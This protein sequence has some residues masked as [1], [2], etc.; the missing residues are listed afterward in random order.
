MRLF[1]IFSGGTRHWPRGVI[2]CIPKSKEVGHSLQSRSSQRGEYRSG[3]E[4]S[5]K[6][7]RLKPFKLARAFELPPC[8]QTWALLVL[9]IRL[10]GGFGALVLCGRLPYGC[11]ARVPALERKKFP[12]T[13]SSPSSAVP[14]PN[15]YNRCDSGCNTSENTSN[16]VQALGWRI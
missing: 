5:A 9:E 13:R 15:E 12:K 16:E 14:E 1:R 11:L 2:D 6:E 4:S 8:P 7:G 3:Q 10:R